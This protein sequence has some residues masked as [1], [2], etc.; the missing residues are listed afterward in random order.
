MK[1]M[2]MVIPQP[3]GFDD[4]TGMAMQQLRMAMPPSPEIP[5]GLQTNTGFL[6]PY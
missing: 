4:E 2:Q 6:F 3:L 1:Q 5:A